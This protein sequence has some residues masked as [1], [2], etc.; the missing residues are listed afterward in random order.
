MRTSCSRAPSS[1][2]R[3]RAVAARASPARRAR[4]RRSPRR[5]RSQPSTLRKR[6]PTARRRSSRHDG[7][8]A[9]RLRVRDRD[10]SSASAVEP[11]LVVAPAQRSTR[12][13]RAAARR[14]RLSLPAA[15]GARVPAAPSRDPRSAARA[16]PARVGRRRLALP[17]RRS[18][19]SARAPARATARRSRA[20]SA[21]IS[22]AAVS[23]SSRAWRAA[24][25]PKRT[26]ARSKPTGRPSPCSG[27]ASTATIP[28]RTPSSR[29]A[30]PRTVCSYPNTRRASSRRRGGFPRATGSSPASARATVVV[31]ARERSGALITADLALEEGREVFTVPGE[32]SSALSAGTNA[33][34]KLGATPLTAASDVLQEFGIEEAAAGAAETGSSTSCPQLPTSSSAEPAGPRRRSPEPSSSS[35][36]RAAPSA[37]E[38]VYRVQ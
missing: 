37:H 12:G 17:R 16:L 32:I 38:G 9:R 11:A 5:M 26:A 4:S 33:L 18:P 13:V 27:A 10:A 19:S 21:A 30:L 14:P 31:E 34:L 7:A 36:S 3:S 2:C 25:T 29:G 22:P 20:R 23:S 28:P 1:V 6:S 24:S 8:C 15:D 35:S